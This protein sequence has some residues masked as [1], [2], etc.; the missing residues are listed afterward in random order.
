VA[1]IV[2]SNAYP[3]L[4][5][6][7]LASDGSL[8]SSPAVNL[9]H[10]DVAFLDK[11]GVALALS[12]ERDALLRVSYADQGSWLTRLD[13]Y[14]STIVACIWALITFALVFALQKI[15]RRRN[16]AADE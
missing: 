5:I 15:Y 3:G 1:Q 16:A 6:K 10:G 11:S 14:R 2:T 9:D 8:P 12:T 7:P 4:W 13:R